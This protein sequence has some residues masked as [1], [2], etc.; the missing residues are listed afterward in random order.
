MGRVPAYSLVRAS[1]MDGGDGRWLYHI[2]NVI[3][4]TEIHLKWL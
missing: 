3:N 4:I 2:V 1:E